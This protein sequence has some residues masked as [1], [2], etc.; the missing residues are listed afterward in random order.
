MAWAVTAACHA[1]TSRTAVGNCG[2]IIAGWACGNSR[3]AS[4]SL[5]TVAAIVL[6]IAGHTCFGHSVC[7]RTS[8]K[9]VVT[10]MVTVLENVTSA[11]RQRQSVNA[12]RG[13]LGSSGT[14]YH[15]DDAR[16]L[17]ACSAEL[18]LRSAFVSR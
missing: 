17:S 18:V 7:G 5:A 11:T 6:V 16:S 4:E 2:M 12:G 13:S 15:D 8:V 3:I 1:G 9:A 14:V 10:M